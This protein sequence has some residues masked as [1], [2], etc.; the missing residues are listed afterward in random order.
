MTP[1]SAQNIH[2]ILS[3][4]HFSNSA[5]NEA[6]RDVPTMGVTPADVTAPGKNY[7]PSE[8]Q[9]EMSARKARK[10]GRPRLDAGAVL[11]E[12]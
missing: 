1:P 8:Q 7:V 10:A 4:R 9:D 3:A 12:V 2:N 5:D 6:D 11:S